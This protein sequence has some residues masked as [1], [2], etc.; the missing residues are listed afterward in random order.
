MAYYCN[1]ILFAIK[2]VKRVSSTSLRRGEFFAVQTA[3]WKISRPFGFAQGRLYGLET[4]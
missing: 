3:T 1:E 2:A 4:T